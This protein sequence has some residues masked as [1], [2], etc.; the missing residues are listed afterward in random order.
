MKSSK[1][2]ALIFL[3]L[4]YHNVFADICMLTP[5]PLKNI[6]DNS[7]LVVD[8]KVISSQSNWNESRTKIYTTHQVVIYGVLKG[9]VKSAQIQV[10]TEGG[11]VGESIHYATGTLQLLQDQVGLFCLIPFKNESGISGYKVYS[12]M[13]GFIGYDQESSKAFGV[14]ETYDSVDGVLYPVIAN[15]TGTQRKIVYAKNFR[16]AID[17]VNGSKVMVAPVITSFTPAIT[18]AGTKSVLTINGVNFGA[19]RGNGFVE[20]RRG[21]SG[22]ASFVRPL[23]SDYISWSDTQIQLLVPSQTVNGASQLTGTAGSGQIKVTNNGQETGTSANSLI[24]EYSVFNT[25]PL[26]LNSPTFMMEMQNQNGSGGYT[27]NINSNLATNTAAVASFTRAMNNWKCTTGVN[28]IIGTNTSI[29]KNLNDSINVITFDDNDPLGPNSAARGDLFA[30]LCTSGGTSRFFVHDI[31]MRFSANAAGFAWNFGTGNA[32]AGQIDFESTALHELGH[33]HVLDHSL[34]VSVMFPS[35]S[36]GTTKRIL[37]TEDVNGGN[38]M[39]G[40]STVTPVC[41]P[42]AIV[43]FSQPTLTASIAVSSTSI[44]SG[45]SITGTVTVAGNIGAPVF[46]WRKNGVAFGSNSA[47]QVI[48]GLTNG[49]VITCVVTDAATCART[50]TSNPITITVFSI[51]LPPAITSGPSCVT[52]GVATTYTAAAVAGANS[53]GWSFPSGTVFNGAN[54]TQTV[55]VTFA[56]TFKAGTIHT[57]VTANGCQS[58]T[59]SAFWVGSVPTLPGTISGPTSGLCL[60]FNNSYSIAAVPNASTYIWT[61]PTGATIQNPSSTTTQL[62]HFSNTFSSGN[63][64]VKGANGVCQGSARSL[65]VTGTPAQPGT[66]S[67]QASGMIAPTGKTYSISPVAT[68]TSYSWT[69]SGGGATITSGQGTTSVNVLFTSNGSKSV[70]V[71]AGNACGLSVQ[72]CKSVTVGL[73]LREIG[74][75][76]EDEYSYNVFPNP[77]ENE[78]V[79]ERIDPSNSERMYISVSDMTGKQVINSVSTDAA[80]FN[81]GTDHL[82]AG[83]YIV[84]IQSNGK[85]EYMKMLKE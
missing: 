28:W 37:D 11:Q 10:I 26:T 36:T 12:D 5:L 74:S 44:C 35:V 68:A 43:P 65:T 16:K 23:N 69:V 60:T 63:I 72:R 56:S 79:I 13:Q 82:S 6:V 78:I 19:T 9:Q 17:E 76:N 18:S 61:A 67:G 40:I 49:T 70:C 42:A 31:D 2:F 47:T 73:F 4:T 52:N 46:S 83:M 1:L 71:K 59:T 66:I 85:T 55:S 20:F 58:F 80:S 57:S 34:E 41:G 64:T 51:P 25:N 7:E 29:N 54:N 77:F 62:I 8:G 48:S 30:T 21:V 75:G 81:V 3:L 27:F 45:T 24:I 38:F 50:I 39:M 53:Y 22:A 15:F 84:A 33:L 14:F 32:P